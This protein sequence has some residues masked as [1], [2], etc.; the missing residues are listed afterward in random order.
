MQRIGA[1][2]GRP[3]AAASMEAAVRGRRGAAVAVA[4]ALRV[5]GRRR[6]EYR[7]GAVRPGRGGA[8]PKASASISGARRAEVGWR[9]GLGW[10]QDVS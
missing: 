3:P 9:I 5:P 8:E 2:L 7:A 6:W 10:A 1:G 4:M